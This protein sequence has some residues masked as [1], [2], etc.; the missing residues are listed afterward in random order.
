MPPVTQVQPLS[1]ANRLGLNYRHEA[2][3]LP[4][5]PV[6][7]GIVDAHVHIHGPPDGPAQVFFDAADAFG[8][9][10]VWSQT[11][12]DE[13]DRLRD[14]YG[15]RINFVAIPDYNLARQGDGHLLDDWLR[16]VEAFAAK[17]ARL[18]KFWSAPRGRDFS[19]T[20]H[21][22]HPIRLAVMQRARELGMGIMT[23]VADPDTW[24]ATH[25]RE[26]R[27]YGTKP[28]HYEPL[29][30]LLDQFHDVPWLGAHMSGDPEHLDHLQ[31][32]LDRHPN[33]H[34]DTSA[35]K[36]M[37]REL[38]KQPHEFRDFCRRNPGRVLF[39]SDI[40]VGARDDPAT[41]FDHYAS[42]FW[43]L[44][45]LFETDYQ[46]PSP[47]VDPDLP[48]LDPSLPATATATLRGA[49][50]D[51]ATLQMMYALAARGLWERIG[52]AR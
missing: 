44:R 32:L 23:H 22:D 50:F 26:A 28:E 36:W 42:R 48:L 3:Q 14:A 33:F 4:W 7:G 24:F 43:A 17:G 11:P 39:G 47:I 21:L 30:R 35:T 8:I 40:V 13:V 52:P 29:E 34:I 12:L 5:P 51:P 9:T 18:V 16:R 10:Q 6:A 45:T 19:P 27:R 15:S 38:S 20:F 46:G 2:A 31:D 37:V 49:S 25:Y 1:P 41:A